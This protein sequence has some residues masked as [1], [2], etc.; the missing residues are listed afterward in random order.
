M[1]LV[2][3]PTSL[4]QHSHHYGI[5]SYTP[6]LHFHSHGGFCIDQWLLTFLHV[7]PFCQKD[8]QIYPNALNIATLW[9]CEINKLLQFEMIYTN[10]NWLQSMFQ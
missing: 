5:D 7:S 2:L 4:N 9:N 10:L 8:Y 3:L 6:E 1:S